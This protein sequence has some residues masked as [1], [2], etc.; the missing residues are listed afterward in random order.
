M[1]NVKESEDKKTYKNSHDE[2]NIKIKKVKFDLA[3][4]ENRSYKERQRIKITKVIRVTNSFK[5]NIE[6]LGGE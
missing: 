1:T 2:K 5:V 4:N 3:K 6:N